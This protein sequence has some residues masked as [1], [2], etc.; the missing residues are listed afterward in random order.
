[1]KTF[2]SPLFAAVAGLVLTSGCSSPTAPVL[3]GP[4]Y[5]VAA[6]GFDRSC[7]ATPCSVA[8]GYDITDEEGDFVSAEV[9]VDIKVSGGRAPRTDLSRP[10]E[11]W[12]EFE[13]EFNTP[14]TY[15]VRVCPRVNPK[16]CMEQSYRAGR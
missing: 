3:V 1:M 11:S 9:R 16:G 13:W 10:G 4:A 14:G 8:V 7:G 15:T 6:I 2:A 12:G 5:R